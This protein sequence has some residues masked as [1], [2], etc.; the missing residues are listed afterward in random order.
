MFVSLFFCGG[1]CAQPM[2]ASTQDE[3]APTCAV[4]AAEA[5]QAIAGTYVLKATA[6]DA[7]AGAAGLCVARL[8]EGLETGYLLRAGH[9]HPA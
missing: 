6:T 1:C 2:H 3:I 9:P 4:V 8:A 7:L 5:G